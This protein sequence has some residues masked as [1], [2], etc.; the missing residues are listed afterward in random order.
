MILVTG[1][2]SSSPDSQ[3][4]I[5]TGL[6]NSL[7]YHFYMDDIIA[8][9]KKTLWLI[10]DRIQRT[11]ELKDQEGANDMIKATFRNVLELQNNELDREVD[12]EESVRMRR[13]ALFNVRRLCGKEIA[14]EFAAETMAGWME[15]RNWW[16]GLGDGSSKSED[17]D[18]QD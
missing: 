12:N 3:R 2:E 16:Y 5:E 9:R 15:Y 13:A 1:L 18:D 8:R 11:Y 4:M 14:S 17:E 6:W 10:N 7:L